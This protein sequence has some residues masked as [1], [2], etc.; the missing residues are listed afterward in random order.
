MAKK[1]SWEDIDSTYYLKIR[2]DEAILNLKITIK[3]PSLLQES[4]LLIEARFNG[5]QRR[6]R[7]GIVQESQANV[8]KNEIRYSLTEDESNVDCLSENINPHISDLESI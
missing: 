5:L 1:N 7:L 2:F 3:D 8:A 4:S 6:V